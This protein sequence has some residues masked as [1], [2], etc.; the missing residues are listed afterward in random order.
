MHVQIFDHPKTK[1]DPRWVW[2]E[3][4]ENIRSKQTKKNVSQSNIVK[5]GCPKH[6]LR[7]S[8]VRAYNNQILL[9]SYVICNHTSSFCKKNTPD[10]NFRPIGEWNFAQFIELETKSNSSLKIKFRQNKERE[11]MIQIMVYRFLTQTFGKKM[12]PGCYVW[13]DKA[14]KADNVEKAKNKQKKPKDQLGT[15]R[16]GKAFFVIKDDDVL[17]FVEDKFYFRFVLHSDPNESG[18]ID[19]VPD[20]IAAV[21]LTCIMER[22][23][24]TM[25]VVN[26]IMLRARESKV[27]EVLNQCKI[28][29]YSRID[30]CDIS[31][32]EIQ[33]MTAF[34]FLDAP[35]NYPINNVV[36]S[37]I[38]G[39][40]CHVDYSSHNITQV[41]DNSYDNNNIKCCI[42]DP[43]C[44]F[45][46]DID[47]SSN[48]IKNS[49]FSSFDNNYS[50]QCNSLINNNSSTNKNNE[51]SCLNLNNVC[52][53]ITHC[54]KNHDNGDDNDVNLIDKYCCV[55]NQMG[56]DNNN[57]S[58][59]RNEKYITNDCDIDYNSHNHC[60]FNYNSNLHDNMN[61]CSDNNVDNIN[62]ENYCHNNYDHISNGNCNNDSFHN[63]NNVNLFHDNGTHDSNHNNDIFY[64][65]CV[66]N[67]NRYNCCRNRTD[68]RDSNESHN[69]H[70]CDE[71]DNCKMQLEILDT[72]DSNDNNNC[73]NVYNYSDDCNNNTS[74]H[75]VYSDCK[76]N[77]NNHDVYSDDKFDFNYGNSCENY[78]A[79]KNND[80]YING[81]SCK[82]DNNVNN[83]NN[84][85]NQLT[86]TDNICNNKN[87]S[88][89][90]FDCNMNNNNNNFGVDYNHHYNG[91][92]I[93]C[94]N[95]DTY[96]YYNHNVTYNNNVNNNANANA[97]T[98]TNC[99]H[100][101]NCNNNK[102]CNNYYHCNMFNYNTETS[103]NF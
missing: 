18:E 84:Y 76:N 68:Y 32:N 85:N 16:N 90:N 79:P 99:N 66:N 34:P 91:D 2:R 25:N 75:V 65:H 82:Y 9:P 26:C 67:D 31:I 63:F 35:I 8:L 87:N 52:N 46:N 77:S 102:N 10:L 39:S 7:P 98:N 6:D 95:N 12:R 56:N 101:S 4:L 41:E 40:N 15:W 24:N 27:I 21:G 81:C 19:S 71:A 1:S 70:R 96:N 37:S 103:T 80:S 89:N 50:T 55:N 78:Q 47:N 74:S 45:V 30:S 60:N 33:V 11:E 54:S 53:Q 29:L 49:S 61:S 43:Y 62:N 72:Y 23:S 14:D 97:N 83:C 88:G 94:Q 5:F 57:A 92:T 86:N 51:N 58:N 93:M 13:D 73:G 69:C 42:L 3:T 100:N 59:C 20:V 48:T 17:L 44:N 38:Y 64:D 28:R 36:E 22:K